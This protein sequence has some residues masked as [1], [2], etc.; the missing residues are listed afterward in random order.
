MLKL[1][2]Y[3]LFERKYIVQL[4]SS[5]VGCVVQYLMFR[6]SI[7]FVLSRLNVT[8]IFMSSNYFSTLVQRHQKFDL[9][10]IQFFSYIHT[11]MFDFCWIFVQYLGFRFSHTR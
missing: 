6:F 8:C 9:Y 4:Y 7:K 1:I 5:Y 11:R 2:P 10:Y 3:F